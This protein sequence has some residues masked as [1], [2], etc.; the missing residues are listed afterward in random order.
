MNRL[1]RGYEEV[2]INCGADLSTPAQ[3]IEEDKI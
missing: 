1:G 3:W 2:E